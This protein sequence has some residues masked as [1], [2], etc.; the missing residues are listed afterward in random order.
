MLPYII[1][2]AYLAVMAIMQPPYQKW[3]SKLLWIP[4]AMYFILFIGF[5]DE[6]GADWGNYLAMFERDAVNMD[7]IDA[8]HHHDPSY[9][10]LQVWAWDLGYEIYFVNF[11]AAI[12][13]VW[14]VSR[15]VMKLLPNP[16][17]GFVVIMSYTMIAVATGYVRQGIAL[18]ITFG[19]LSYL[20]EKK[21]LQF[22]SLAFFAASFHRTA[23]L[24]IGLALFADKKNKFFKFIGVSIMIVAAYVTFLAGAEQKYIQEYILNNMQSSGAVIRALMNVIP[25]ILFFIYKNRWKR[26]FADGYGLWF[27]MSI[28]AFVQVLTVKFA[29]TAIDRMGLYLIPLQVV[30]FGRLPILLS[31]IISPRFT[32]TLIVLYY[33]LVY[34]VFLN[35]ASWA[36]AWLPYKNILVEEFF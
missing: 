4:T 11:I 22:I 8:L 25:A 6:V 14:G 20:V 13:F 32:T 35:F 12:L 33:A 10:L 1:S 7:Y 34:F 26:L 24:I 21:M 36:F 27:I 15:F 23:V 19:A 31:D 2:F 18:G 29:S 17:L 16:W 5:R 28:G 3:D 30:V 9:W